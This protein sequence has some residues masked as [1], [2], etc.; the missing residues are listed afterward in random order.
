MDF[1]TGALFMWTAALP[2]RF[3]AEA[4]A[5]VGLGRA[6]VQVM[7][8]AKRRSSVRCLF[9]AVKGHFAALRLNP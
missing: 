5:K 4:K 1:G 3:F 2:C 7:L 9:G 8:H 6:L